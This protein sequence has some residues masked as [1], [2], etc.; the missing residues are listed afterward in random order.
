MEGQ[1]ATYGA[2]PICQD[3]FEGG[4]RYKRCA[5]CRGYQHTTCFNAHAANRIA[6]G[7]PVDCCLCRVAPFQHA[8]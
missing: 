7:R 3:A 4:Q 1:P 5:Q 2:C 8:R 6:H